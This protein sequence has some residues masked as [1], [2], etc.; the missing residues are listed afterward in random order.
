MTSTPISDRFIIYINKI[1]DDPVLYR[2]AIRSYLN[3]TSKYFLKLRKIRQH[4]I[5]QRLEFGRKEYGDELF[6]RTL[7]E[8]LNEKHEEDIDGFV[9]YVAA[10]FKKKVQK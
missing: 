6:K 9:Y 5:N 4:V 8:I 10:I 1:M 7:E 2:K 3:N